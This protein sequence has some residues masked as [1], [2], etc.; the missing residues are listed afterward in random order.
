MHFLTYILPIPDFCWYIELFFLIFKNC[1]KNFFCLFNAA[2]TAYGGSQTRDRFRAVATGLHH[3]P[4]QHQI[5][6][7]S[8]TYTT[9]HGHAGSLTH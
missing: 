2:S 1:F 6:A 5:Q 8:A 7:T 9:A 4:Q 3:R